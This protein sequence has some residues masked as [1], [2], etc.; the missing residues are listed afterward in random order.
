LQ[1]PLRTNSRTSSG[2]NRS[3]TRAVGYITT[4]LFLK[5]QN[6][7]SDIQFVKR[8][9]FVIGLL[10]I[11]NLRIQFWLEQHHEEAALSLCGARGFLEQRELG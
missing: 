7:N 10:D 6:K 9:S 1:F 8:I 2:I 3:P 4:I 11:N 5:V